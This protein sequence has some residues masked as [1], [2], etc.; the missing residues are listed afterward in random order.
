MLTEEQISRLAQKLNDRINLPIVGEGLELMLFKK[1]V[2]Q[3]DKKIHDILPDELY[4]LINLLG[5]GF[6][7]EEDLEET[8]ARLVH[9]LNNLFD[10]PFIKEE[11][12]QEIIVF[13]INIIVEALRRNKTMDEVLEHT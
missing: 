3:M 6:A 7:E 5:Q 9:A 1:I 10:I 2:R 12:E 8:K 11:R 13:F 4:Q